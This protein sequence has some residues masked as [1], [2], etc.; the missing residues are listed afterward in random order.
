MSLGFWLWALWWAGYRVRQQQKVEAGN[1]HST[2]DGFCAGCGEESQ[3]TLKGPA[4][5]AATLQCPWAHTVLSCG[6]SVVPE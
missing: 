5:H 6:C 3:R 4:S 2:L 1:S